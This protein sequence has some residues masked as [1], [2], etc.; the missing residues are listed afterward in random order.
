MAVSSLSMAIAGGGRTVER[1]PNRRTA[2][3]KAPVSK[4]CMIT[5]GAPTRKAKRTW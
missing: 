2:A 3:A 5:I 4:R 1:M